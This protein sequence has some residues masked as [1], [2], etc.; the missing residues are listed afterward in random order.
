[1]SSTQFSIDVNTKYRL[2]RYKAAK[3]QEIIEEY[4]KD[5]RQV[6]NTDVINYLLDKVGAD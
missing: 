3:Q 1:M 2:Y 5:R 6:T 4:N